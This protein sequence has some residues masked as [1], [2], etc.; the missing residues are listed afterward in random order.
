M[1]LHRGIGLVSKNLIGAS[2]VRPSR[3]L[4]Y[5]VI[6]ALIYACESPLDIKGLAYLI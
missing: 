6:L 3:S 1:F 4:P 5:E 2:E